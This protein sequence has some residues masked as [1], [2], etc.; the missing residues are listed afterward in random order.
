MHMAKGTF[1]ILKLGVCIG[2]DVNEAPREHAATTKP[3]GR[4]AARKLA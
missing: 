2:T 4:T 3:R 1:I